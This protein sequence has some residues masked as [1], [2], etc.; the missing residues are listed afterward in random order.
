MALTKSEQKQPYN[1]LYEAILTLKDAEECKNFFRDLCTIA[2]MRAM[3]QRFEVALMLE[4]GMIYTDIMKLT[5]AS[6]ATI[7]RVNR[8]LHYGD[9]GYDAVLPR[10]K[11]TWQVPQET[12]GEL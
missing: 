7:S 3:E 4:K 2:E 11:E 12:D 6:S 8:V 9:G 10:M 1:T 5:G